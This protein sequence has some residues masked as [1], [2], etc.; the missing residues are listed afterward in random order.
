[1]KIILKGIVRG[2]DAVRAA[3]SGLMAA[4][5]VSNHGGRNLDSCRPTLAA[6]AIVM[7]A[8]R[9]AKLQD[10]IEVYMDGGMKGTTFQKN[11]FFSLYFFLCVCVWG[12]GIERERERA[13]L[14]TECLVS[15][16]I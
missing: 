15:L 8:L 5:V 6:L 16:T 10:A 9:E 12:G 1:M 4:I 7:Q 2:D 11:L 13:R 3:R 14:L